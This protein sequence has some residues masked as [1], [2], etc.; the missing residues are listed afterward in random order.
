VGAANP[1]SRARC[2]SRRGAGQES[3]AYKQR[4]V[5]VVQRGDLVALQQ[6]M[7]QRL[8]LLQVL[9]APDTVVG[10]HELAQLGE[11]VQPLYPAWPVIRGWRRIARER[12]TRVRNTR[13]RFS[14]TRS[15]QHEAALDPA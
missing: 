3:C 15:A 11:R 14:R 13:R 6:Q 5:E 7:L 10:Q 4:Q 9:H 2:Q 1:T 8:Q 12:Q